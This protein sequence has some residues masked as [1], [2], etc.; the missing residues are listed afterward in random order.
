MTQ[1]AG[2]SCV[3]CNER[4]D[5]DFDSAF[6]SG[7][8]YPRHNACVLTNNDRAGERVM[9]CPGCGS[10]GK[11]RNESSARPHF[12][13]TVR[14]DESSARPH[15]PGTVSAT[16]PLICPACGQVNPPGTFDCECGFDLVRNAG[17]HSQIARSLG[18]KNLVIGI[19]MV[20]IGVIA[21]IVAAQA[22][23]VYLAYGLM[24]VGLACAGR[25]IARLIDS[26]EMKS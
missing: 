13:S 19:S 20:A 8:G 2:Q 11:Q 17:R 15:F 10:T 6:C 22:G 12:P 16:Q 23:F 14:R 26:K 4:I 25:G 9:F 5:G 3:I 7:C 1:L 24:F 21:A 18:F